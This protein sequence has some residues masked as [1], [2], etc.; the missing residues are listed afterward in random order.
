MENSTQLH[1]SFL[2][3]CPLYCEWY[4]HEDLP[5]TY[6]VCLAVRL[7]KGGGGAYSSMSGTCS[8]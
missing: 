2:L 4:A 8:M 5:A 3:L 7:R 1:E 6:I